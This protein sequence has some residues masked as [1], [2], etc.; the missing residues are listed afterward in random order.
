MFDITVEPLVRAWG[1]YDDSCRVPDS[2]AVAQLRQRV[3]YRQVMVREDTVV[4]GDSVRIDL[5]GIAVGFAVDR[6][7][8]ILRSGGV[9]EGLIDAGGDIRVFGDR[10]WRVGI[11][12]PREQGLTPGV[13]V[14]G[15]GG[16]NIRRLRAVL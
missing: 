3:D 7:V 4:L 6:A 15:P 11:K 2:A 12:H 1:F 5:G 8:A 16:G 14:A 13:E 10:V 9:K